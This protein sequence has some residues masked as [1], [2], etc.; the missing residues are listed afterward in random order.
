MG[1]SGAA[2]CSARGSSGNVDKGWRKKRL[3]RLQVHPY[4][5]RLTGLIIPVRKYLQARCAESRLSALGLCRS[6]EYP[7]VEG[8]RR[9][10]RG[11]SFIRALHED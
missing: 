11:R 10:P 9:L 7:F 2:S 6:V 5:Y 3:I 8:K 4:R 1:L